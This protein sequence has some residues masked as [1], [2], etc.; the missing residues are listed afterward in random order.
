M[1][2]VAAGGAAVTVTG[3]KGTVYM[4]AAKARCPYVSRR[5]LSIHQTSPRG[6]HLSAPLS[7]RISRRAGPK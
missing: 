2:F 3:G 7:A 1:A 5:A 4:V 6:L